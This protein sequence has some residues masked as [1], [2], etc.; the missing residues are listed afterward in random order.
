MADEISVDDAVDSIARQFGGGEH[1][2][3]G[4][5]ASQLVYGKSKSPNQKLLDKL[6][7]QAPGIERYIS[8][9]ETP[10]TMVS[11]QAGDPL[12]NQPENSQETVSGSNA[13]PQAGI[14]EQNAMDKLLAPGRERL[15]KSEAAED[16]G[17]TRLNPSGSTRTTKAKK[18]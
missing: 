7:E 12:S 11:D 2:L 1:K 6:V 14:K 8:A 17:D 3:A 9:P 13:S 15:E 10:V 4:A 16:I 5:R 18:D